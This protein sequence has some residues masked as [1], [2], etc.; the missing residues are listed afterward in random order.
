MHIEFL[1]ED[2]SGAKMLEILLPKILPT[3]YTYN[4]HSYKGIG[5]K[6]PAGFKNDPAVVKHRMLL[7]NLPRLLSG[8]GKTFSSYGSSYQAAVVVICDL[9]CRNESLFK[10]ELE[11]LLQRCQVQ[12]ETRFCLA[13][14]E[15]EAWFLGDADAIIQAYP[16]CNIT[17]MKSYIQDSICGTWEILADVVYSGGHSKLSEKGYQAVG[18]EKFAWAEKI[19]PFMDIDQNQSPSF[20]NFRD[21]VRSL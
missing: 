21:T 9:D 15:G 11:S 12:P 6:I 5:G 4:I 18:K 8:F 1:I 10:N 19:T 17:A 7:D 13:I 16:Q 3:G 20:C 2:I 14:E